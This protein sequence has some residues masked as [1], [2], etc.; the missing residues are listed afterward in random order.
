M[1]KPCSTQSDVSRNTQSA[2]STK[3]F[4]SAYFLATLHSVMNKQTRE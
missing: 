2:S 1:E 4:K 3:P